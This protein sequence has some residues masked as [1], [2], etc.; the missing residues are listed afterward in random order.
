MRA[1]RHNQRRKNNIKLFIGVVLIITVGLAAAV[2]W[3]LRQQDKTPLIDPAI[4]SQLDFPAYYPTTL[5][6]GYTI[7]P[8]ALQDTSKIISI[9][10]KSP[11]N[12]LIYITQQ[13]KPANFDFDF[14]YNKTLLITREV[15]VP[16]GKVRIGSAKARPDQLTASI[17]AEPTW[18]LSSYPASVAQEDIDTI[19]YSLTK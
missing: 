6:K 17:V 4:T 5:P 19:F 15:D 11:Q 16:I 8:P 7:E 1:Y 10:I 9:S 2:G 13:Q 14:F 18:I 12:D 3:Q